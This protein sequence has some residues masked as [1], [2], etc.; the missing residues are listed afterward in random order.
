MQFSDCFLVDLL[1][2][3]K[4]QTGNGKVLAKLEQSPRK[5]NLNTASLE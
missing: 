4:L 5:L 3:L 1:V 2:R